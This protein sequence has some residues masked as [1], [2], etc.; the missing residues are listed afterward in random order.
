VRAGSPPPSAAVARKPPQRPQLLLLLRPRLYARLCAGQGIIGI[1][2]ENQG[3]DLGSE[4][5]IRTGTFLLIPRFPSIRLVFYLAMQKE[6]PGI[7]ENQK[8]WN[9]DIKGQNVILPR[10]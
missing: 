4:N 2:V 7:N 6:V 8:R 1:R 5:G 3:S 9:S 10:R